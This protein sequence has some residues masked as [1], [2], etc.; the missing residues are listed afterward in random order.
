M[1]R[2]MGMGTQGILA[3]FQLDRFE[4]DILHQMLRRSSMAEC[5]A[6]N[7]EVT[8]SNPVVATKLIQLV[9]VV[10]GSMSVSKTVRC[11]FDSY[12]A[13]QMWGASLSW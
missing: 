3:R 5:V 6:H 7:H 11:R 1:L 9:A 2:G 10:I 13:S 4:S 12:A 8:G